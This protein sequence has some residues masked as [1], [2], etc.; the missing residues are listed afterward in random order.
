MNADSNHNSNYND[1]NKIGRN[2]KH[3]CCCFFH[4]SKS[5]IVTKK[6]NSNYKL[7]YQ[8]L[9][10]QNYMKDIMNDMMFCHI[11][12][13]INYTRNTIDKRGKSAVADAS[14]A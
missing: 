1:Q 5:S 2:Q 14:S 3:K 8:H 6:R 4:C 9:Q 10:K 13:T 12:K 11:F 7:S